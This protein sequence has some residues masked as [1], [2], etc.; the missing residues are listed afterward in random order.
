VTVVCLKLTLNVFTIAHN[1][2]AID[3]FCLFLLSD[4]VSQIYVKIGECRVFSV[5][6]NLCEIHS[7]LQ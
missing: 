7:N 1:V 6:I 3:K 4:T 2:S 5:M